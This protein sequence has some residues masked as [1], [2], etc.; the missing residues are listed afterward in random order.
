MMMLISV[1]LFSQKVYTTNLRVDYTYV[2][3]KQVNDKEINFKNHVIIIGDKLITIDKFIGGS[4]TQKLQVMTITK[5]PNGLGTH[6][7]CMTMDKDPYNG[8]QVAS[9]DVSADDKIIV[10]DLYASGDDGII[11]KYRSIFNNY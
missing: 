5:N 11:F 2:N 7:T 1:S 3:G 4:E 10:F 9:V 6:Y 8:Y